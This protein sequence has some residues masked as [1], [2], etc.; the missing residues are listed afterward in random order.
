VPL[1]IGFLVE[2]E[3]L[4]A[5][6]PVGHNDLGAAIIEPLPQFSAVVGLVTE[7]F[8]GRVGPPDQTLGNGTIMGLAAAQQDGKKTAFSI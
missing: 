4:L 8:L 6:G 5:I 7:K 3:R 2:A 1:F